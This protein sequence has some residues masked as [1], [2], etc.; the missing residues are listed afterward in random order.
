MS[1]S[2][3][4][5]TATR[6]VPAYV[7]RIQSGIKNVTQQYFPF[8]SIEQYIMMEEVNTYV[9]L[10]PIVSHSYIVVD[11]MFIQVGKD[12]HVRYPF[13]MTRTFSILIFF[14]TRM[15]RR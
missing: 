1:S 11:S 12:G 10:V 5:L 7:Y 8:I 6:M 15:K 13:S 4:G 3:Y 2:L 9:N 14:G